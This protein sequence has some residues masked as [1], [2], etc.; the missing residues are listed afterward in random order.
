MLGMLYKITVGPLLIK[1]EDSWN[2]V[3]SAS[4]AT[5][6]IL[7]RDWEEDGIEKAIAIIKERQ[8]DD[9]DGPEIKGG[10]IISCESIGF[11]HSEK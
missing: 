9:L 8:Q 1:H 11:L 4:R 3:T 6:N 2:A 10:E 5:Y 7:V